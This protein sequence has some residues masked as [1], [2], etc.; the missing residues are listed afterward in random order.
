MSTVRRDRAVVLGG[1]MAGLLAARVLADSYAE[2]TIVD[3]DELTGRGDHR[4]GV[5]QGRHAHVLLARG[6]QILEDLLP[7][8]TADL[9]ADGAASG[10]PVAHAR[11]CFGGHRFRQ[12]PSGL[13]MLSM[14]RPFL[15]NHVAERV[16]GLPNVT[17]TAPS[18]VAGLASTS[19]GEHVTGARVF[20][21]A[22]GSAGETLPADLVVDATGRGSRAPAWLAELGYE[23]PP[24]ERAGVDVRYSSGD[25]HLPPDALG[26]DWGCLIAPTPERPV[27]AAFA[28]LERGRWL[29]TMVG[30]D[31]VRP[32]TDPQAVSEF[33]QSLAFPD[34]A[35]AIGDVEPAGELVGYR[36]PGNVRRR[37]EQAS[38][39]PAGFVVIG[40]GVCSFNPIYAQGMTV[41]AA[42]VLALRDHLVQHV[43]PHPRELARVVAD[44]VEIPW[45]MALGGD[46]AFPGAQGRQ[47]RKLRFL[48]AYLSRLHAAAARD[49]SLA[50]VFM[51]VSGLVDPPGRMLRPAAVARVVRGSLTGNGRTST[52][53]EG[54]RDDA[55]QREALSHL[56][57]SR[58]ER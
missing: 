13:H 27:G 30:V 3:R 53:E 2:V 42:Q 44:E 28:R 26:A 54:T 1:G 7:G 40:D 56:H 51:R 47:T 17:A 52:G 34:V 32:P 57:R 37:Y 5:P 38:R 55:S 25:Y 23:R 12:G 29:L 11:L 16:L 10:D 36:F 45:E 24:E 35:E 19:D 31:G 14:S 46:L 9:M 8:L 18:D 22:D 41:A 39:L 21:R 58:R 43:E 4:R 20:R 15:E 6:L 50:A 48:D 33:V 49:A